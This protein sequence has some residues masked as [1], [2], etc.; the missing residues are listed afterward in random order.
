MHA[1][2]VFR[3]Q[4]SPLP[5]TGIFTA[6]F[7]CSNVRPVRMS[8]IA[9]LPRARVQGYRSQSAVFRQPRHAYRHQ[10][11]HRSSPSETCT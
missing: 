11:L 3:R 2:R 5:I 9:L 10:I 6:A 4:M 7:T 1:N 8:T